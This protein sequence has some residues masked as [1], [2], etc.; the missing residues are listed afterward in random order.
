MKYVIDGLK[1]AETSVIKMTFSK[2]SSWIKFKVGYK[3]T[4]G[5]MTFTYS[6]FM[7]SFTRSGGAVE[8]RVVPVKHVIS[9]S[10]TDIDSQKSLLKLWLRN[11]ECIELNFIG[12]DLKEII[13]MLSSIYN[14][15]S[16]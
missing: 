16:I 3:G 12:E 14:N 5:E 9:Y 13:K 6:Q 15:M 11:N 8:Y 7:F 2:F 4:N 10:I 1:R